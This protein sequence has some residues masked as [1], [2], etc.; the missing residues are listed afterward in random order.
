MYAPVPVLT[1]SARWACPADVS[2]SALPHPHPAA[3]S[4]GT[5]GGSIVSRGAARS[6]GPDATSLSS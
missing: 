4:S 5:G 3:C 6:E 2:A 1:P